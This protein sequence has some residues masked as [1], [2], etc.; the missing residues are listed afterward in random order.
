MALQRDPASDRT[1]GVQM[2]AKEALQGPDCE[3][4]DGG[5]VQPGLLDGVFG[6]RRIFNLCK[7][8]RKG[9]GFVER[10][11]RLQRAGFGPRTDP[12]VYGQ[13]RNA[14]TRQTRRAR[15]SFFSAL[16]IASR[17]AVRP[18]RDV[19]HAAQDVPQPFSGPEETGLARRG[20]MDSARES[21]EETAPRIE[22]NSPMSI[23]NV[24][25]FLE[26]GSQKG[27]LKSLEGGTSASAS[28]RVAC[29]G[30]FQGLLK[31]GPILGPLEGHLEGRM[32][33]HLR[34]SKGLFQS[35]GPLQVRVSGPCKKT[36]LQVRSSTAP[37][38]GLD[39]R[40]HSTAHA[41]GHSAT[42]L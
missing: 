29:F 14:L 3:T 26:K 2:A 1:E 11:N 10:R 41:G 33:G 34:T 30:R 8:Q 39:G 31:R 24:E 7:T 12:R 36:T 40:P 28:L 37:L 22:G 13:G 15:T 19:L 32:Q 20:Q 16:R 9:R 35:E 5:V 17:I 25:R 21:G 27:F 38:D 42:A 18:P 6:S 4:P 23:S